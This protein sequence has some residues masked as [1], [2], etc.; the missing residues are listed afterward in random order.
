MTYSSELGSKESVLGLI[1]LGGGYIPYSSFEG[2]GH[3]VPV[4]RFSPVPAQVYPPNPTCTPGFLF[5]SPALS[6]N[7]GAQIDI[8][9]VSLTQKVADSYRVPVSQIKNKTRPFVL[10][11]HPLVPSGRVWP[12]DFSPSFK[13]VLNNPEYGLTNNKPGSAIRGELVNT[14]TMEVSIVLI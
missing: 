9:Q 13:P 8:A 11:P 4:Y 2:F 10:G 3:A 7:S 5:F 6:S 12:P 14:T 1:I